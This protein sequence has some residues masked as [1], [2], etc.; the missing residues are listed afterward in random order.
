M[1]TPQR[2]AVRKKQKRRRFR[3]EIKLLLKKEAA[4]AASTEAKTSLGRRKHESLRALTSWRRLFSLGKPYKRDVMK[5][6]VGACARGVCLR[7][8]RGF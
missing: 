1:G 8:Y 2:P 6:R 5:A 7:D 3:K 4:A